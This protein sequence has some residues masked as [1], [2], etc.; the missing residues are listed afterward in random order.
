MQ[1]GIRYATL[2]GRFADEPEGEDSM[3]DERHW[4]REPGRWETQFTPAAYAMIPTIATPRPSPDG[5]LVAYS[6]GYDGRIDLM[7]VPT[8][9]GVPL[10][11][12]DD[13]SMQ[14]PD[15]SQRQASA[16]AWTP[17]GQ[18]IVFASRKNGKLFAV[19][20]RGGKA[21]QIDEG[22]GNHHSPSISPDGTR[23]AYVAERGEDVDIYIAAMDGSWA[24]KVSHGDEYVLEPKWSPDGSRL[25]WC[26]W[27]HFDMPWDEL[28]LV[29]ADAEGNKPRVVAGGSRVTN[30]YPVWSPDGKRIAVISDREGDFGNLWVMNADGSGAERLVAESSQHASPA[31]SPDG[32]RI[33][34]TRNDDGDVQVCLWENGQTRQLTSAPGTHDNVQ[35]LDND[36]LVYIFSSPV[37]PPDVY[38]HAADGA[39]RRPLTQS[40]TGGVLGGNLIMPTHVQWQSKDGLEISGLLITPPETGGNGEH[41]LVVSI[42]GGPVG[43][44]MYNWQPQVQYMAQR[45]WIVLQ[46]NYRG[47]KGY[48]RKFMEKLYGDWGGGDLQDNITGAEMVIGQGLANPRKVVAMGGSA[49]GYSTL[50]C[51]T[52]APDFFR[53]GVCRF[54][55]ADLTTFTDK[56]WIFER[57]YIAK[58]MGHPSKNSDLYYDRSPIHFVQDVKEPLLIL[59][60]E[61]DIVCHP[62]QMNSMVEALRK[63]GKDVEYTT[64]PGEGHG[65]RQ[66]AHIIDDATRVDDFVI[67]KV[68]NR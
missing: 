63:A 37:L 52:K 60:G 58:L 24:R 32:R 2:P 12:S 16:I 14:G 41:P 39:T 20:A 10:Q 27:P 43:Q 18:T 66:V 28:A 53:A 40:A 3:S 13:P 5:R 50:I 36:H 68:L 8:S 11:L 1:A 31:W 55:I 15:P 30:N 57:H 59:Q 42:H 67:R 22:P 9:G 35:W 46:P 17:D 49:G 34:Y 33:A 23:V 38:V 44:L 45:G 51:M 4:S 7:L 65:W 6:R 62:S 47:S 56:T 29:V 25:L 64:Y 19:P 26:Q 54:G 61:E 48:G 21:R